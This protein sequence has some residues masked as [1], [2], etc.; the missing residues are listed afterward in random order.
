MALG[1]DTRAWLQKETCLRLT[2][3]KGHEC[4]PI[5]ALRK[6]ISA[7]SEIKIVIPELKRSWIAM[8]KIAGQPWNFEEERHSVPFLHISH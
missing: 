3:V 4:I 5:K 2:Y 1:T 8:F 7:M 6:S